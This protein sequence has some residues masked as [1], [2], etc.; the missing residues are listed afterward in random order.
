M[1]ARPAA[2]ARAEEHNTDLDAGATVAF[3]GNRIR[4][5]RAQRNL[6]LQALAEHTGL[7]SSMLSLVERGKTSPSIG[8]L[9]AISSALGIHMSDLLDNRS[10]HRED[11]VIQAD[12][13]PVFVTA[14]GVKRRVA[15]TDDDRGL[16]LVINEYEPGT[17]SGSAATHHSGYEYGMVLEGKL[18]IEV[19]GERFEL[20]PGDSIAYHSELPHKIVNEGLKHVRAVW[21][22]LER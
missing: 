16:E 5:L 7:S 8:T 3:I 19:D 6:T 1:T 18:T 13:Q 12:D 4:E 9:V 11:R 14:E 21:V 17:G 22:N 15:R 20:K 2:N 10:Q